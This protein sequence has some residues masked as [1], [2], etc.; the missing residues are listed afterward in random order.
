MYVKRSIEA[1]SCNHCYRR[2]AIIITYSECV[3]VKLV[4]L[5]AMRMRYIVICG[6]YRD[7]EVFHII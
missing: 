1:L 4:I 2:K 6:L 5:L 3:S 7:T